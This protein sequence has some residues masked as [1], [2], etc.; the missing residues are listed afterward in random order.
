M[1]AE[2]EV[3]AVLR[4]IL[5]PILTGNLNGRGFG[6]LIHRILYIVCLEEIKNPLTAI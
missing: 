4:A 1:I 2:E 5:T 3:L 6:V